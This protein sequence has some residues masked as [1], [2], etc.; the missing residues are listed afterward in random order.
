MD[1]QFFHN[2]QELYGEG[3]WYHFTGVNANMDLCLDSNL[4]YGMM[5]SDLE[6]GSWNIEVNNGEPTDQQ[7]LWCWRVFNWDY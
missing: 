1:Q 7:K 2:G 5:E 4:P 3:Q 6:Y